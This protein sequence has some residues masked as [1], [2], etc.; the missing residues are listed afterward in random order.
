MSTFDITSIRAV[1]WCGFHKK[2]CQHNFLGKK[3]TKELPET[4]LCVC[5]CVPVID[6]ELFCSACILLSFIHFWLGLCGLVQTFFFSN[7]LVHVHRR[8]YSFYLTSLEFVFLFETHHG[9]WE[10]EK[11]RKQAQVDLRKSHEY[12]TKWSYLQ[13][14]WKINQTEEHFLKVFIMPLWHPEFY[15][16]L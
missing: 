5:V 4:Q 15:L 7:V 9:H 16:H 3:V 13:T 14:E 12:K 6:L 1:V 2:Q 10:R 8:S 11:Q